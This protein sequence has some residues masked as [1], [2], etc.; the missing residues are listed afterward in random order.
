MQIVAPISKNPASKA[1]FAKKQ[2]LFFAQQFYTLYE[3]KIKSET[4]SFNY[5]SPRTPKIKKKVGH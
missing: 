4:A 1:K 2:Q 5:F 3:K